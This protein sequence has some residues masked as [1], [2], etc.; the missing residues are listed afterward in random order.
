[1]QVAMQMANADAHDSTKPESLRN[2]DSYLTDD[3]CGRNT[4]QPVGPALQSPTAST[5]SEQLRDI[6]RTEGNQ[7]QAEIEESSKKRDGGS[8]Q[9][10]SED[11]QTGESSPREQDEN[12]PSGGK[13]PQPSL[14]GSSV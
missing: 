6:T 12:R 14:T 2:A 3:T 5:C 9:A 7:S 11:A 10:R 1:M 13:K 4:Q 8:S